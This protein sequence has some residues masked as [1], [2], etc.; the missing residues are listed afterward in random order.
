MLR[1]HERRDFTGASYLL[2]SAIVCIAIF[3]P[4]I[5]FAAMCFL[6]I[7]DTFAAIIGMNWGKRKIVY[8]VKSFEGALACFITT[9][10]FGLFF[11]DPVVAVCGAIAATIAETSNIDIDDNVKIPIFSGIVMSITYLFV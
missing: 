5:A 7:G 4:E 6:S 8:T 9:F 1:K 11:L 10:S 3:P 2:T